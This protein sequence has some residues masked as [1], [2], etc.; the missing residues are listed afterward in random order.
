MLPERKNIYKLWVKFSL[1]PQISSQSRK[2]QS[3]K[4]DVLRFVLSS[5]QFPQEFE[6]GYPT[7][8]LHSMKRGVNGTRGGIA[9]GVPHGLGNQSPKGV[10]FLP[11]ASWAR[12]GGVGGAGPS[13]KRAYL[14]THIGSFCWA[15]IALKKPNIIPFL[16]LL[17]T[18]YF[19]LSTISATLPVSLGQDSHRSLCPDYSSFRS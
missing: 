18:K 13:E 19:P 9:P 10:F 12:Q 4:G 5:P 15:T 14:E 6:P 17:K 7:A 16:H 3:L 11:Q 8:H 1:L 2:S